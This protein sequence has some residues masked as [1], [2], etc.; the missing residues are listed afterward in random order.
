M[1]FSSFYQLIDIYGAFIEYF[2]KLKGSVPEASVT[3]EY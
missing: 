1:K 3:S 2:A